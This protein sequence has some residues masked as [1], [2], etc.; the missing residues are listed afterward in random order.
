MPKE[1]QDNRPQQSLRYGPLESAIWRNEGENG[2]FHNATFSRH[3]KS[4]E[5]WKQ[6]DSFREMDLPTLSKLALDSHSAIQE[7]KEKAAEPKRK[8]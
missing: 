5:D 2:E 3:Y 7:L 6:T 1:Q 4:G 8:K